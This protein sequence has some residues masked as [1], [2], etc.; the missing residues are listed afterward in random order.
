MNVDHLDELIGAAQGAGILPAGAKRPADDK[1]PWPV[2]LMVGLGAWLS[3]IPVFAFLALW[4]GQN[5]FTGGG[6]YFFGAMSIG[7]AMFIFRSDSTSTFVEH[8]GLP[9]LLAGGVLIW[10][11]LL[12]H[13]GTAAASLILSVIIGAV[14]V[15]VSRDWVRVVLGAFAC[16]LIA[17]TFLQIGYGHHDGLWTA[18]HV[19]L[20]AWI[21]AAALRSRHIDGLADGIWASTVE[22]L[23]AGWLPVTLICLA[24]SAGG[25]FLLSSFGLAP[26]SI[27]EIEL[28]ELM[29][30]RYVVS[31]AAA[32][33]G[34]AWLGT[35]WH[36]LRTVPASIAALVLVGLSWLN[37]T[38]GGTLLALACC[39]ASGRWRLASAAGIA[40]A[41]IIGAFYYHLGMPLADKALILL[42]A[43]AALGGVAWFAAPSSFAIAGKGPR[44]AAPRDRNFVAIALTGVAVLAVVNIGIWRNEGLI[45]QSRII[46]V[47]LAPVDPRSLMQGDYMALAFRLEGAN[48]TSRCAVD[49]CKAVARLDSRGVATVSRLAGG[50]ALAAGE[51]LIELT[52]RRGRW[53]MASD[54]WYFK[55]GE[56]DRWSKARFG[57]FRVD[58]TGRALLVGMRG[59]SLEAL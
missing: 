30:Y 28:A 21:A 15:L 26:G 31:A 14:A 27:H 24:V 57:E 47:E 55:E 22:S 32:A 52:E 44:Q 8:L 9:I 19:T 59:A 33:A 7:A 53:T 11:G 58:S 20:L 48:Q 18:A 3:V 49:P 34:A 56:A 1:Q 50:E 38:L 40:A 42:G 36:A 54:A 46:F 35:R 10:A 17:S 13:L 6:A 45:A 39:L 29:D 16:T 25:T 41:W 23:S 43:A 12:G 5:F 51:L 2:L 37:P 4:M